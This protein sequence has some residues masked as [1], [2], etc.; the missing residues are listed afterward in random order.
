MK[1]L[2]SHQRRAYDT[3]S[4]HKKTSANGSREVDLLTET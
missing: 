1:I 3:G 2:K 4:R